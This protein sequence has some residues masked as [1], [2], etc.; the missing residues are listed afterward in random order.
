MEG[1][2]VLIWHL[3]ILRCHTC[4][5]GAHNSLVFSSFSWDS[6]NST[7]IS[8]LSHLSDHERLNLRVCFYFHFL[9]GMLR[10]QTNITPRGWTWHT[11]R[12]GS[13]E[14][15]WRVGYFRATENNTLPLTENHKKILSVKQNPKKILS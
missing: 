1:D 12:Q 10:I 7:H 2:N 15:A 11:Y 6:T 3:K 14:L 5:W 8:H 9:S 13:V 4:F